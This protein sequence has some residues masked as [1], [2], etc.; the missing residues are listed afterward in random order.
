MTTSLDQPCLQV[1][2]EVDA[3]FII[4]PNGQVAAQQK[5][6]PPVKRHS[7][8]PLR[9]SRSASPKKSSG[10][11]GKLC[12]R[13]RSSS[14]RQQKRHISQATAI[15]AYRDTYGTSH[16]HNR[17]MQLFITSGNPVMCHSQCLDLQACLLSFAPPGDQKNGFYGKLVIEVQALA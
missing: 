4:L 2:G 6:T 14:H 13:F 10:L 12:C 3:E 15:A 5:P 1:A 16:M 9:R 11:L 7:P 8:G 17:T